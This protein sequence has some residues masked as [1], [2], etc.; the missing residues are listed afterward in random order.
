MQLGRKLLEQ[1]LPNYEIGGELG[2]GAFGVV[3]EARHRTLGRRV[4][5]KQLPQAFAAD[6][7]MRERFLTE[8]R[9]VASL[10]HPHIVP[11]HDFVEHDGL[12]LF[13]MELLG[14]GSLW[15]R[16]TGPGLTTD[17]ACASALATAS[18]LHYAHERGVLHRDIKPENLL[19]A[20]GGVLKLTDFGIARLRDADARLTTDGTVVGTPAY[21]APEQVTGGE[22]GPAADLYSTGVMLYEL[23]AGK[24]P[25]AA[26]ATSTQALLQHLQEQ[27]RPLR[28]LAP[29][30]P[31]EIAAVVHRCLEKQPADRYPSA[32]AFGVALAEAATAS[33]GTGWLARS[34][35][36]LLGSAPMVAATER[37][38]SVVRPSPTVMVKVD[39]HHGFDS[40]DVPAATA[41]PQRPVSPVSPLN[42]PPA[43]PPP[44]APPTGPASGS[45][46][47]PQ[48]SRSGVFAAV[49][50][51]LAALLAVGAWALFGS[52][53]D[54]E[55]GTAAG[56]STT[57][58]P[59][60]AELE[61]EFLAKCSQRS[62]ATLD[63]CR[64]VWEGFPNA[65]VE[66]MQTMIANAELSNQATRAVA[67]R[68]LLCRQMGR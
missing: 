58:V 12:C 38:I 1:A 65:T 10:N 55:K 2:R 15:D 19:F 63:R 50:V 14:H 43:M 57:A 27:P 41:A 32:E 4:A 29:A 61:V 49:A 68:I 23:L 42:P 11:V 44:L 30:V 39:G 36:D 66:Q 45:G 40:G 25:F 18:A 37:A 35:I 60:R 22:L 20:E 21:M 17:A 16:L 8:A 34:G 6:S 7:A 9:V 28:E 67:E 62:D 47:S 13:V 59:T 46:S 31:A 48:R 52:G 33:F 26:A 3:V 51:L 64:C 24:L 5:V 56:G 54:D 53:G